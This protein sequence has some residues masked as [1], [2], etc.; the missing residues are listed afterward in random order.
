MRYKNLRSSRLLFETH[1]IMEMGGYLLGTRSAFSYWETPTKIVLR[2]IVTKNPSKDVK[3]AATKSGPG[4]QGRSW[5][6]AQCIPVRLGR[7]PRLFIT[8]EHVNSFLC[9]IFNFYPPKT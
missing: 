8:T 7:Q 6:P 4:H 1:F 5:L 9:M 3:R 2:L